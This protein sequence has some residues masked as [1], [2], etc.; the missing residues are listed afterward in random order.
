M[1]IKTNGVGQSVNLLNGVAGIDSFQNVADLTICGWMF[2]DALPGAPQFN[3]GGLA[4]LSTGS[5]A[6]P[7]PSTEARAE[8]YITS[9]GKISYSGQSQDGGAGIGG[10][11]VGTYLA[12][13]QRVHLAVVFRY[14]AK[15]V[16]FFVDGVF[17]ED[18][19][20]AFVDNTTANT[21]SS[22]GD[23]NADEDV[24]AGLAI[25]I[26]RTEDIRFYNRALTPDEIQ[27][28]F[29]CEGIDGIVRGLTNRWQLDE[30]PPGTVV[31]AG[32]P[33]DVGNATLNGV[34]FGSPVYADTFKCAFRRRVA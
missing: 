9:T 32:F 6:P 4:G 20:A 21:P 23:L 24:T 30:Q 3:L 34:N 7:G 12:A 25:L 1:S 5:P 14:T 19:A 11:T 13:G 10:T 28:I 18:V 29:T 33:R 8:V 17:A 22:N 31:A 16:S 2:I 26:G 15:V 27:T